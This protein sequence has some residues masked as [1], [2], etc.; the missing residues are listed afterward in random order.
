MNS[1]SCR[2]SRLHLKMNLR[3]F[4]FHIKYEMNAEAMK[5]EGK[6]KRDRKY[7]SYIVA[8]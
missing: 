5:H 2:S 8:R 3:T 4:L 7:S 6:N 1:T